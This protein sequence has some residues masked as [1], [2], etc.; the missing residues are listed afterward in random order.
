[1]QI[2]PGSTPLSRAWWVAELPFP[3]SERSGKVFSFCRVADF[4]EASIGVV[5][6]LVFTIRK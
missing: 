5:K 2:P 1:M 3:G 4:E 6:Q